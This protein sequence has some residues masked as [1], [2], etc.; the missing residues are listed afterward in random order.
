MYVIT[1]TAL[2]YQGKDMKQS[3][4]DASPGSS[5][6]LNPNAPN[7]QQLLHTKS[8]GTD[9]A[10]IIGNATIVNNYRS[11][12]EPVPAQVITQEA[13][14]G[15]LQTGSRLSEEFYN[16]ETLLRD[17]PPGCPPGHLE[18]LRHDTA[19]GS[20]EW[21][22]LRDEFRQWI[23]GGRQSLW[24]IGAPGTGKSIL[25]VSIVDYINQKMQSL[26]ESEHENKISPP[27]TLAYYFFGSDPT[28]NTGKSVVRSILQQL[29]RSHSV[30]LRNIRTIQMFAEKV[31]STS[32]GTYMLFAFLEQLLGVLGNHFG[33][34][35]LVLDGLD[36]CDSSS[37]AELI[38]GLRQL[39]GQDAKIKLLV[40]SQHVDWIVDQL[41]K[42][43]ERLELNP[44]LLA[45]DIQKVV[46]FKF[47]KLKL[48]RS[49][50]HDTRKKLEEYLLSNSEGTFLWADLAIKALAASKRTLPDLEFNQI[51]DKIPP[52]LHE[53]YDRILNDICRRRI[54]AS[55]PLDE[56]AFV[57]RFVT[58]A[59]R[60][61]TTDEIDMAYAIWKNRDSVTE[62]IPDLR[63]LKRNIFE[64]SIPLVS[65]N[66][67]TKVVG[68]MHKSVADY[69]LSD[70][71]YLHLKMARY[72]GIAL[73]PSVTELTRYLVTLLLQL[74]HFVSAIVSIPRQLLYG[75]GSEPPLPSS[76]FTTNANLLALEI[77]LRYIGMPRF[78]AREKKIT[79][80]KS[81]GI[82]SQDSTCSDSE[83]RRFVGYVSEYWQ[84]HALAVDPDQAIYHIRKLGNLPRFPRIRDSLLLR[85]AECGNH[86]IVKALLRNM[87]ASIDTEDGNGKTALHL[88]ALGGH[89]AA[90]RLL[91]DHGADL[92]KRD[93]IGANAL[94]WA[95]GGGHLE[96]FTYLFAL[97]QQDRR[98]RSRHRDVGRWLTWA[99]QL[100]HFQPQ[101]V[102]ASTDLEMSDNAG[103][104]LLAWSVE[105]GSEKVIQ[106]LLANG[107]RTNLRY[108]RDTRRIVPHELTEKKLKQT[109]NE[110]LEDVLFSTHTFLNLVCQHGSTADPPLPHSLGPNANTWLA[111]RGTGLHC[112]ELQN[113]ARSKLLTCCL[114][115]VPIQTLK[116]HWA[117][118]LSSWLP[119]VSTNQ[120]F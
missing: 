12:R 14:T 107:A 24:I 82:P 8:G 104:T 63:K 79:G 100:F 9:I 39:L 98:R 53:A 49:V 118:P 87:G 10:A 70:R 5:A 16:W 109:F 92:K 65:F 81:E 84:D 4:G 90:V 72:F 46:R 23:D 26:G 102:Y 73:F 35:F 11:A 119:I 115:M 34:I 28:R 36:E 52:K 78:D 61:L 66:S 40:T 13:C 116:I 59:K 20:C 22:Q 93:S 77:C 57:L 32:C 69:L 15:V 94:H 105:Q 96:T 25:S 2:Y 68:L 86:R 56:V 41:D 97:H 80:D 47:Q 7:I 58:V 111:F 45:D 1:N 3:A 55:L 31:A 37:G 74:L 112:R 60:Q 6:N 50:S 19:P 64:S 76:N 48:E 99:S 75:V 51:L 117:G 18:T 71:P 101:S 103:G 89:L 21:L 110:F 108:F 67:K 85:S 43:V 17:F 44:A 30:H 62:T 83:S 88:A 106:F 113:W 33:R 54:E 38:N 29:L 42:S 27:G 120:L 91:V 114:N 95:A